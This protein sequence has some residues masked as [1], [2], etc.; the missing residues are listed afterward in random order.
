M[1]GRSLPSP[2]SGQNTGA[3]AAQ[4]RSPSPAG[5]H[6]V[7]GF[8][9]TAPNAIVEPI[10]PNAMCVVLVGSCRSWKVSGLPIGTFPGCYYD[11]KL[12]QPRKRTGGTGT[13]AHEVQ[14]VVPSFEYGLPAVWVGLDE[15][16][17]YDED[18]LIDAC[19]RA[20]RV[21]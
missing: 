16:Y 3:I 11:G 7:Y 18:R 10:H 13:P 5:P 21:L 2:V 4:S 12:P 6:L 17:A 14:A 20:R 15:E 9:T 1:T 19:A 8:P